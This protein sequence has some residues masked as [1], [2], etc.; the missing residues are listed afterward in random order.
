MKQKRIDVQNIAKED[1]KHKAIHETK[2]IGVQEKCMHK[3]THK[4]KRKDVLER[5]LHKASHEI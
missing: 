4:I 1:L 5:A 2:R 3:A